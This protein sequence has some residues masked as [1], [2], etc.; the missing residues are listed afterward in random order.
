MEPKLPLPTDSLYK[1]SALFGLALIIAGMV[2]F[3]MNLNTGN[4]RIKLNAEAYYALSEDDPYK[5]EKQEMFKNRIETAR[6]D[7]RYYG[8]A[9]GVIIATGVLLSFAGFSIWRKKVQPIQLEMLE[10]EKEKLELEVAMLRK[11]AG[12]CVQPIAEPGSTETNEQHP[13]DPGTGMHSASSS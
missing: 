11:K 2:L 9:V 6:S 7:Q 8:Y 10:L 1:F 5:N 12:T 3:V 4:A 13:E